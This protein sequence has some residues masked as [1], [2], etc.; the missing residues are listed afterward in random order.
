M[1]C[2]ILIITLFALGFSASATEVDGYI[3]NPSGDTVRGKVDVATFRVGFGKK[4]LDLW[5]MEEAISFIPEG[6]RSRKVSAGE[7]SGYGF[8]YEEFWYHFVVLDWGS[9]PWK[10][11]QGMFGRKVGKMK[12]FIHRVIDDPLP[13]YKDYYKTQEKSIMI[14]GSGGSKTTTKNETDMYI[15]SNDLGYVEVAPAN[16]RDNKRFKDF[17]MKYLTLEEGFLATVAEDARF[18]NAEDIVR[19]YAEWKKRN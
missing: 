16:T 9:N 14:G 3:L 6:G 11:S 1:R 8:L 4:Q 15:L 19:S 5:D 17:L 10:K 13:L 2:I 18:S 7:V 12:A